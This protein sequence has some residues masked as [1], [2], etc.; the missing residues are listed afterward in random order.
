MSGTALTTFSPSSSSS[1]RST[2]CVDGCCGPMLRTMRCGPGLG[3]S[4]ATAVTDTPGM[5]GSL[6]LNPRPR[7]GIILAQRVPFPIVRHH[8]AAQVRM[9]QEVD[10]EE[11]ENLT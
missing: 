9:V 5:A 10:A 7:D 11:V 2:P 4:S 3:G 1:R 8:D 6:I